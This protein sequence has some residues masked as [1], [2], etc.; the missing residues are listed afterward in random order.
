MLFQ[1]TIHIAHKRDGLEQDFDSVTRPFDHARQRH[2]LLRSLYIG[3]RHCRETRSPSYQHVQPIH[4]RLITRQFTNCRSVQFV[5]CGRVFRPA[6]KKAR[7]TTT[8]IVY[9]RVQGKRGSSYTTQHWRARV[10]LDASNCRELHGA[11]H[12]NNDSH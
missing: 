12:R 9:T 3:Y 10:K 5:C 1:P 7:M 11:I 6:G 4:M 8:T 2:D